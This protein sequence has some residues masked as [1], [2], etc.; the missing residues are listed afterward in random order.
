MELRNC[1][2]CGELFLYNGSRLICHNCVE[3][4]EKEFEIVKQYLWD[5]HNASLRQVVEHTG[6]KEDRVLKYLR[7]GR[8]A[9]G[10][11]SDIRLECELCGAEIK[12]GRICGK[13]A[14]NI[15]GQAGAKAGSYSESEE[16]TTLNKGLKL[17]TEDLLKR[18][19]R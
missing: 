1:K 15:G 17:F 11:G 19:G 7:E 9:L 8:I 6:V 10:D 4:E 16:K 5:H 12:Y 18:R 14:K 13:C 2:R 3:E